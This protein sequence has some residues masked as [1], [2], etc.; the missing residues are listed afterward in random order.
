MFFSEVA[1]T[2][3]HE[4]EQ[5]GITTAL[6]P[7]RSS[8][9]SSCQDCPIFGFDRCS[10]GK[11]CFA[12][13]TGPRY[14]CAIRKFLSLVVSEFMLA[15]TGFGL[16]DLEFALIYHGLAQHGHFDQ[17]SKGQDRGLE[18]SRYWKTEEVS[19]SDLN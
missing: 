15:I 11:S 10:P 1:G 9:R 13:Y 12:A 5:G 16:R 7:E 4:I 2:L 19:I 6:D 18:Y 8:S 14:S 3:L 17:D